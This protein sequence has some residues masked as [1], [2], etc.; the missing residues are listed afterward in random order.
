MDTPRVKRKYVRKAVTIEKS[1]LTKW[2]ES[3]EATVENLNVLKD[4]L[5]RLTEENRLLKS[6]QDEIN[7][8]LGRT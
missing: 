2:V 4:E 1:N 3:I 6:K 8:L 5:I 7:R